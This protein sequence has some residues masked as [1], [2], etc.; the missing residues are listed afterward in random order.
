[1]NDHG[2]RSM[3]LALSGLALA[4]G[5]LGSTFSGELYGSQELT[6][7]LANEPERASVRFG[8]G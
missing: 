2:E 3:A 1:M 6:A 7:R 4:T 5:E 8:S